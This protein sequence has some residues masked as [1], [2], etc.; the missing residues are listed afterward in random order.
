MPGMPARS[1]DMQLV[2]SGLE[3]RGDD[4][5]YAIDIIEAIL[6]RNLSRTPAWSPTSRWRSPSTRRCR[7]TR[8]AWACWPATR[9]ARRPTWAFRWWRSRCCTAR[10][11]SSS[12]WTAQGVQSEEVQPWNPADFCTEEPARVTVLSRRPHGDGARV[13]L[14]PGGPLRA[15]GADLSAGHRSRRQ[16]GMGSRPDRSPLRRRH[17]LPPAAGDCAGHGRRAHGQ[18]AGPSRKRLPHER[19]PRGAADAGAA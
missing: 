14:R 10:D 11:I 12:I 2:A 9:C 8:A 13:A 1:F 6:L 4:K 19:R 3:R 16:L 5:I 7:P 18:C 17:E 15:R